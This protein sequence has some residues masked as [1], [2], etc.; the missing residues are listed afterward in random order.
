MV[1]VMMQLDLLIKLVMGAPPKRK[2][3]EKSSDDVPKPNETIVERPK[4]VEE[5]VES[6]EAPKV[7]DYDTLKMDGSPIVPLPQIKIPPLFPQR[8]K[9]KD[10]NTK[11]KKFFV[12]FSNLSVDISLLEPLQEMTS[13][14][15]VK[16]EDRLV[17]DTPTT[18]RLLMANSLIKKPVGVL[19]DVLVKV[20]W[21]IFPIDFIIIDCEIDHKVQIIL[22]KSLLATE[23]ALADVE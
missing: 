18:I 10:D 11:F 15:V 20:D 22:G 23:R 19:Y 8:L 21:F 14:M 17:L 6:E 7:V 5:N 2:R 3:L 1:K 9:N 4:V 12:K 16:K 13:T